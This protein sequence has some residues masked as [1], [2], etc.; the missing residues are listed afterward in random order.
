MK[1]HPRYPAQPF[2]TLEQARDWVLGFQHWYN[3]DHRHS[4]LQFVT[5]GERHRGEAEAIIAQ[6]QAVYEAARRRH[7]ERWSGN[8]RDWTLPEVVWLNPAK[9]KQRQAANEPALKVA[10]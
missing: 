8:T 4:A 1:Y 2:E 7:P 10:S 6:R 5:P 9:P 3:E